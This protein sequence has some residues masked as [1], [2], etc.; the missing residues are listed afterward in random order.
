MKKDWSGK[1]AVITGASSGLGASFAGFLAREGLHVVLTARRVDRLE[2]V[3]EDIRV[4]GG[5]A[6]IFQADMAVEKEREQLAD[7][8]RSEIGQIDISDQQCRFWMVWVL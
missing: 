6:T 8:I 7:K 2:A 4:S 1:V 5:K 3:Q